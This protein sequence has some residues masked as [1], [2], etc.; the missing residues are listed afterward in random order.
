MSRR[1][2][3]SNRQSADQSKKLLGFWKI[4]SKEDEEV[5]IEE[6]INL[7]GVETSKK[8]MNLKDRVKNEILPGKKV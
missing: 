2:I 5:F 8:K 1:K 3:R 7:I 6:F 4:Q